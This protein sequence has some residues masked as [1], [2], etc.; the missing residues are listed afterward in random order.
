ME[1]EFDMYLSSDII[2]TKFRSKKLLST[3]V[4]IL[5]NQ[6]GFHIDQPGY[7]QFHAFCFNGCFVRS[8]SKV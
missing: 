1:I 7:E 5:L 2:L 8:E 3:S 4:S 6:F